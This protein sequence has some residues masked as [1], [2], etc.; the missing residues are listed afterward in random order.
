MSE[1]AD[2]GGVKPVP[3]AWWVSEK[4]WEELALIKNGHRTVLASPKEKGHKEKKKER[5]TIII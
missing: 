4:G 3:Q 1:H 5:G 2:K